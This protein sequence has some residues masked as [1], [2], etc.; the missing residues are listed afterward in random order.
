MYDQKCRR[1]HKSNPLQSPSHSYL[2]FSTARKHWKGVEEA[3]LY[4]VFIHLDVGKTYY[5]T[6]ING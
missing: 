1:I 2:P 6:S 5:G 3:I 4:A